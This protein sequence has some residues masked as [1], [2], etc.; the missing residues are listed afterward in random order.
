MMNIRGQL[1]LSQKEIEDFIYYEFC[2]L[3]L[4]KEAKYTREIII[5]LIDEV[6][7]QR[8]LNN[9]WKFKDE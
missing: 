8:K 5:K 6:I 7:E 1:K 2:R 3:P 4:S 9:E